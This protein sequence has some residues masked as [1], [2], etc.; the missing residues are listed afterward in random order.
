MLRSKLKSSSENFIL[1]IDMLSDSCFSFRNC[2]Q[3]RIE[4]ATMVGN[5]M[6]TM[7]VSRKLLQKILYCFPVFWL[8]K[9]ESSQMLNQTWIFGHISAPYLL[10]RNK[11]NVQ[12]TDFEADPWNQQYS[13]YWSYSK[14]DFLSSF[15]IQQPNH[16][17]KW[18][19]ILWDDKL[20][21]LTCQGFTYCSLEIFMGAGDKAMMEGDKAM[22]EGDKAMMEGD[23]VVRGGS[24]TIPGKP[25]ISF[26]VVGNIAADQNQN[27]TI[28]PGKIRNLTES[29]DHTNHE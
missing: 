10:R 15:G 24:P 11:T 23:K 3:I 1:N 18:L 16:W 13:P 17:C 21:H 20:Y 12:K 22:M 14:T 5:W 4:A 27:G 28:G 2:T 26:Q 9:V 6:A 19:K 7:L 8:A 25:C 29:S